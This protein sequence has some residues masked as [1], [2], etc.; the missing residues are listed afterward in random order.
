MTDY[1]FVTLWQIEA[2]IEQ[3]WEEI[4]HSQRWPRWWKGLESVIEIRPGDEQGLGAIRRYTWEARLPHSLVFD[5]ET[6][7]VEPLRC[8]EGIAS[9][10][11]D[12]KGSWRFQEEEGRTLLR[13]DWNVK[14]TK[15]WMNFLAPVARPLFE[16][17]HNL[18]MRWGEQGL[19]SLLEKRVSEVI[20]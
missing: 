11:L 6:T 15:P 8:L 1:S 7:R 18:I 4:Y 12:G 10:D 3:V 16:W 14:T 20:R 13:Y 19:R 5:L 17:N 2:P 9:G